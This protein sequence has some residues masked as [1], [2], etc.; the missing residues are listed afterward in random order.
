MLEFWLRQWLFGCFCYFFR[1]IGGHVA[2]TALAAAQAAMT[3]MVI[4]GV[5]GAENTNLV[6]GFRTD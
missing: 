6:G 5:F 1:L 2:M 4:A 3:Q